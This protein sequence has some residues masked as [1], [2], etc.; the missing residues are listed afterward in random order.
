MKRIPSPTSPPTVHAAS[1]PAASASFGAWYWTAI[2]PA[3][4][5]R[6]KW[7]KPSAKSEIFP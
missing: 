5:Y 4:R 2:G 7:A 3:I 6:L 1:L